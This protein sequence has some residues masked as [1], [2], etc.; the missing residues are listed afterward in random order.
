M[1]EYYFFFFFFSSRRRHTIL[2]CDWSSDVCSSD[3]AVH[4]HEHVGSRIALDAHHRAGRVDGRSAETGQ[5]GPLVVA[6]QSPEA[7]GRSR[8]VQVH[9]TVAVQQTAS[10]L[11]PA[12]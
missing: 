5:D 7:L 12:L 6:E 3:L 10:G 8:P 4:Q 1:N 2:T 11:E 9:I